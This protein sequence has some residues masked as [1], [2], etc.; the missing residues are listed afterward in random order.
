MNICHRC[1]ESERPSSEEVSPT[2]F[3]KRLDSEEVSPMS[4]KAFQIQMTVNDV[5]PG[6][7]HSHDVSTM[8]GVGDMCSQTG[9]EV[10]PMS[11]SECLGSEDTSPMSRKGRSDSDDVS[12][13]SCQGSDFTRRVNDVAQ[14]TSGLRRHA[15]DVVQQASGFRRGVTDF[16]NGLSEFRRRVTDVAPRVPHSHDVSMISRK[17]RPG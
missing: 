17:T 14:R 16:A 4:R 2:S 6:V 15:T 8:N 10:P 11:R 13:K 1:R 3:Y 5:A 9:Q 12:P 7:P